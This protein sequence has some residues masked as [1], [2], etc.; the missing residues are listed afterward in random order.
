MPQFQNTALVI[1]SIS[2]P[3]AAMKAFAEGCKKRG[4]D[5]LVIGDSKSPKEF[6]LEGCK[7]VSIEE[8][9][10][11]PFKLAALLPEKH[12]GRKNLGYLLSK[13]KE[14]ILET[15]DDNFP[16]PEFWNKN[17]DIADAR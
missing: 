9:R 1:T 6:Q 13:N 8:Q 5:F 16:H 3:N 4:I 12:Y 7:F 17:L 11:L 14:L 2:A 15:D 10:K